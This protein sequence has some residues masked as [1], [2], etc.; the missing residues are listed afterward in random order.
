M[1]I[2]NKLLSLKDAANQYNRDTSTIKRAISNGTLIENV[3]CKKFG[4]D[5]VILKSALEKVYNIKN[6]KNFDS[7]FKKIEKYFQKLLTKCTLECII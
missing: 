3:D 7:K 1:D 6:I 2:W 4:R 5:W